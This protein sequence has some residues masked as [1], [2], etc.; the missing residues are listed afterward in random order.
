MKLPN[1]LAVLSLAS[2]LA[3]GGHDDDDKN[4]E[5]MAP[6]QNCQACHGSFKV[7]GT[8]FGSA[9]ADSGSGLAGIKVVITDANQMDTTL[10]TNA[11]GNF[12]TTTALAL[13]LKKAAVLRNGTRT[14]MAGPPAG[15]CNRCH[16]LPPG[17]GAA[18]RLFAN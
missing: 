10:T 3:C 5:L 18:G 17:G 6:G 12:Y 1:L 14:E 4:N 13:P 8:V 7:A 16:T 11:A 15:D 2:C 9:T